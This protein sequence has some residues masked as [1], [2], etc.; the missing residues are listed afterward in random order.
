MWHPRCDLPDELLVPAVL[1][2][3]LHRSEA[4]EAFAP[5]VSIGPKSRSRLC[6]H[7]CQEAFCLPLYQSEAPT[8]RSSVHGASAVA[9]TLSTSGHKRPFLRQGNGKVSADPRPPPKAYGL[10]ALLVSRVCLLVDARGRC[11]GPI[12]P[13]PE[14]ESF[15]PLHVRPVFMAFNTAVKHL[16]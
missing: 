11:R 13:I 9:Q 1:E 14:H 3:R 10:G 16:R 5:S 7:R 6:M 8:H 2:Q 12:P 15:L 4:I